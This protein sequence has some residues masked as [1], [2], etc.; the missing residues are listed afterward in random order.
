MIRSDRAYAD[1]MKFIARFCNIDDVSLPYVVKK[2]LSTSV[3]IFVDRSPQ[4][5]A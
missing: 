1:R 2:L 5:K 3:T 4:Y